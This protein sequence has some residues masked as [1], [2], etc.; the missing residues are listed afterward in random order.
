MGAADRI[1]DL[2]VG[3]FFRLDLFVI[4]I[5]TVPKKRQQ[6]KTLRKR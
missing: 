5:V 6:T 4:A 3:V 2:M 1:F